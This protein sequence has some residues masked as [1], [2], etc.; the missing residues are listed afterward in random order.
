MPI[1]SQWQR[2]QGY[3]CTFCI[4]PWTKAL[5]TNVTSFISPA[6]LGGWCQNRKRTLGWDLG[7]L[8]KL[9]LDREQRQARRVLLNSELVPCPSPSLYVVMTGT[10]GVEECHRG[11][12]HIMDQRWWPGALVVWQPFLGLRGCQGTVAPQ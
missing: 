3:V 6:V 11:L 5:F 8:P 7:A 10:Q 4:K 12:S 9:Q 1:P 2:L